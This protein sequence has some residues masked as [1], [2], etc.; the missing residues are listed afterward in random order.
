MPILTDTSVASDWVEPDEVARS[1]VT[2]GIAS[3]KI[4]TI[5]LDMHHHAKGQIL[6]VQRGAL[7]CRVE[8][9]LWIVP[10]GSAIWIPGG[11]LHAIKATGALEG[12]SAFV[13]ADL[14][15]RL[16]RRCCTVSVKPLL[17][18]LLFRAASLPIFYEEAGA[19]SRLMAVLLDEIATAEVED[20]HLPMPADARLR[21]LID[22]MMAAPSERGTLE[23]WAKQAGLSERTLVRLISRE[24]GMS[25]GRW[26]QQLGV[27]LA[28][29]WL[30]GGASTQ[31]VAADLG[32]ESVPSFV[33]MFR[34]T[35]GTSP[36]R[37]MA[38]RHSGRHAAGR[39]PW[40]ARQDSDQL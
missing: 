23:G 40:A 27:M 2:Y 28:V 38:E 22:L 21:G 29:Q 18:E 19:N 4:G 13:A 35:L 30:A 20:L 8:G 1:V 5:E 3:K 12:Y 15:A 14:D 16:P 25:F 36:V 33:T 17:R 9:G 26:R 31:Q 32:Y 11:A 6:L 37:Y 24:T 34:K 39:S 10:P 7:S